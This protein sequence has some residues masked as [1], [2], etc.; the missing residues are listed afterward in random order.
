MEAAAGLVVA[1]STG[2][3][4]EAVPITSHSVPNFPG[5]SATRGGLL[6]NDGAATGALRQ[7]CIIITPDAG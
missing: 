3:T 7:T 1:V 4:G 5:R 2:S 6:P